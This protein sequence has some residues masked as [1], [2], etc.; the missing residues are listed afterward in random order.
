MRLP[1]ASD[2]GKVLGIALSLVVVAA[3]SVAAGYAARSHAKTPQ[4]IPDL[5]PVAQSV[6]GVVQAVTADSITLQTEAGP[7]T[8]QIT[9]STSREAIQRTTLASIRP[10]DWVNAGG[11]HHDQTVYALT[12]L[13]VIPAADLEAGR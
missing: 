9:S 4:A 3:L 1:R 7:V 5:V 2:P 10:G 13:V 6:K 11:V 8:F 12:A